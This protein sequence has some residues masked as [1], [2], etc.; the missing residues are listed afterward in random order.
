MT[1][2]LSKSRIQS[3][4]QCPKRLWLEIHRREAVHWGSAAQFRMDEGSRFGELARTLLGG[5]LL[6][7]ADHRH[8]KQALDDTRKALSSPTQDIP[9][10]FEAAFEHQGVMVR[11]DGFQ[12]RDDGDTMIEV[13]STTQVK[14]EY[15]WDCAIQTWVARG[16]GRRV[17]RVMLAHVDNQF[18]Y[19]RD[20]DYAGFLA[21]ADITAE[22][23]ALLPSIPG[24]V[25]LLAN[26]AAGPMPEIHTGKQCTAPYTCPCLDY[27]RSTEPPLP[28]YPIDIL[29]RVGS[30]ADALREEGFVDLRDVPPDRLE[31][32]LHVRVLEAT[33]SGTPFVS[34][35]LKDV[36]AGI[37][38]P[39]H[40]LD[41]ETISFVVPRWLGTRPFQQLPFQ[42]SCHVESRGGELRHAAFLDVS[43]Q[44][45]LRGFVDALLDAIE[46]DG[47]ILVW[48]RS[49]EASRLRELADMFPDCRE[50]LLA[51][52]ERMVDLLPIY[53]EH[54]YHPAQR[55]SWSIKAVLPTIAPDLDYS[56][57]EIGDGM[58][59]QDGYLR[60]V[61]AS[62]S[63][64]DRETL[65]QQLL[66]YCE[67]DTL[68]MVR[69]ARGPRV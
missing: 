37:P 38:Y 39:R 35:E 17:D 27:C 13:K 60:A 22:V 51:L 68:A 10:L 28:D 33:R 1:P 65:R 53:R 45:P 29:P 62:T 30:L 43:G 11:V 31:R 59:A 32:P 24:I 9:M 66:E 14:E 69:L 44:S 56:E 12:V 47:P 16:E 50:P 8:P 40:Y 42:F 41:F 5:G 4:R 7:E 67:R 46:P 36:L 49:F 61:D 6:I 58:A 25:A 48:N 55:G 15:L 23:E 18:V 64:A 34:P 26:V 54:Y 19:E 63:T 3:G 20:G 57:L 2:R 52:I 21:Q